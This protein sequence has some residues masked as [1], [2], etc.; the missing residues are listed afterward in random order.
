MMQGI[1]NIYKIK[2]VKQNHILNDII[3]IVGS[4]RDRIGVVG[5]SMC[6]G[7]IKVVMNIIIIIMTSC[8]KPRG[9]TS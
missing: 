1:Y 3:L 9:L 5:K 8:V 6:L 2:M 7:L 4:L